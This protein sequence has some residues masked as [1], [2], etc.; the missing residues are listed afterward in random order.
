MSE[1]PRAQR[2]KE[3]IPIE[4]VL[5]DYGY[6]VHSDLGE[7]EQQFSCDLHGDGSDNKPSAR[8]YPDTASWYCFACSKARDAIATA[9]EKEGL[10]FSNAC[11]VLEKRYGLPVWVHTTQGSEDSFQD[12]IDS[13]FEIKS[14][15]YQEIYNR[16]DTLLMQQ[17]R[18]G[19][20]PLKVLLNFWEALDKVS[21]LFFKKKVEEEFAM[22]V[23]E[24]LRKRV[25]K[26]SYQ[27]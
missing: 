13:I 17:M 15:T 12:E 27:Q 18:E 20:L 6:A 19:S 1:N 8:V 22:K 16:V 26:G 21:F 5:S 10:D 25:V 4:Q 9:Q 23:L 11:A 14:N 3:L 7:R 24:D 2:I